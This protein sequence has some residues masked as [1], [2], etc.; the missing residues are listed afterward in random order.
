MSKGFLIR[1]LSTSLWMYAILR[2]HE[3]LQFQGVE[4][5]FLPR[6]T[7]AKGNAELLRRTLFDRR[8]QQHVPQV[9]NRS[10]G[11]SVGRSGAG[12]LSV[13]AQ[14][15]TDHHAFPTAA[16]RRAGNGRLH[17]HRL[18]IKGTARTD[19]VPIA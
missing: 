7:A 13:R 16:K 3:W 18:G 15:P 17:P 1:I 14:G 5:E 19:L 9:S 10:R 8:N 2:R 11:P 4:R 6:E 12:F